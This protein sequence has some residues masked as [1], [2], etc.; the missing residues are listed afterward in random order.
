MASTAAWA[1]AVTGER[2]G[3][4]RSDCELA[5]KLAAEPTFADALANGAVSKAQAAALADAEQPSEDE[6]RDLL[7]DAAGMSVNELERRVA[8][9]NLDRDHAPDPVVSSVTITTTKRRCQ[10]HRDPRRVGR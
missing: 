6:Q 7:D 10:R 5:G 4:A 2:R 9:F 8:R 1:A 3:K